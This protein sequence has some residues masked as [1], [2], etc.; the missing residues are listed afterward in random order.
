[1]MDISG[2]HGDSNGFHQIMKR[3]KLPD[4]PSP[5]RRMLQIKR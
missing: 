4:D 3:L 5:F 1:M 2:I